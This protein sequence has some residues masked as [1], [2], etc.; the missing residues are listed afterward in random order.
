MKY[1]MRHYYPF[2]RGTNLAGDNLLSPSAWD[3]VRMTDNS[4]NAALGFYLPEDRPDWVRVCDESSSAAAS[5]AD[6]A[7]IVRHGRFTTVLSVGVGRACLEYHLKRLEPAVSLVCTEYSPRVVERLRQVFLECDRI[8]F[9]DIKTSA[10]T[11]AGP[12]CL[13]LLN[14]VDTELDDQE[15]R[16]VFKNLAA[17]GVQNILVVA[18]GFLTPRA[19]AFEL[20]QRMMNIFFRR[21]LTFAGYRRT[22]AR[23]KELWSP[24]F[25]IV[26]ERSIGALTGFYLAK[27]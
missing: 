1:T 19:L 15:W 9:L 25:T 20:R 6:I 24:H 22:K 18:S 23:F 4:V 2:G 17:G 11:D 12:R 5:A 3:Q 13:V 8:E 14:R 27:A 16:A 26:E 10:W 21:R 7:K